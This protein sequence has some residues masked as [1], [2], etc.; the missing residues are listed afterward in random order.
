MVWDQAMLDKL[1]VLNNKWNWAIDLWFSRVKE[2]YIAEFVIDCTN[3]CNEDKRKFIE[4][5]RKPIL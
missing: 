4:G 2:G 3:Y 5:L 1:K